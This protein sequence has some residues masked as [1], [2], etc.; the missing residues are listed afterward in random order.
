MTPLVLVID[1]PHPC[2]YH[3]SCSFLALALAFVVDDGRPDSHH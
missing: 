2:S 3:S 1:N